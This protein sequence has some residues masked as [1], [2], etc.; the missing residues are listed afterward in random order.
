MPATTH[1]LQNQKWTPGGS[2][3]FDRVWKGIYPKVFWFFHELF[4][5]DF[6]R[7]ADIG[8]N[9]KTGGGGMGR[10]KI[11]KIVATNIFAS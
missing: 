8:G 7:K 9:R 4:K 10:N 6:L 1:R 11:M 2:K 5:I 3:K